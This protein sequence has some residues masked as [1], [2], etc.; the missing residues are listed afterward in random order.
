MRNQLTI[1]HSTSCFLVKW[2]LGR[3]HRNSVLMTCHYSDLGSAFEWLWPL[4]NFLQPIRSTAH[5]CIVTHH[6]YRIS[7]LISQL[8]FCGKTSGGFAKCRLLSQVTTKLSVTARWS[9]GVL[10][11]R[12]QGA[13]KFWNSSCSLFKWYTKSKISLMP[14]WW[15]KIAR[16]HQV[17]LE[18][19]CVDVTIVSKIFQNFFLWTNTTTLSSWY[20]SNGVKLKLGWQ[21]ISCKRLLLSL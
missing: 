21:I 11:E 5:I 7:P 4:G 13:L 20:S 9:K 15:K 3:L 16:V 10:E 19:S 2:C 1:C 18:H 8:S 12:L 6:L 14:D 17:L